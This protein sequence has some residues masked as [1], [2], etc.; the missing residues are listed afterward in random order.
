MLFDDIT[1]ITV[2][3]YSPKILLTSHNKKKQLIQTQTKKTKQNKQF[4]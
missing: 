2:E 4:K 1:L 3:R